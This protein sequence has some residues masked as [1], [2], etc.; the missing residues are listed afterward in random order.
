M[1]RFM[2]KAS[3]SSP[4]SAYARCSV[5]KEFAIADWDTALSAS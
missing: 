4:I 5:A 3:N 2:R 1:L